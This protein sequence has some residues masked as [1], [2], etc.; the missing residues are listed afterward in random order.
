MRIIYIRQQDYW[1]FPVSVVG[2]LLIEVFLYAG[3]FWMRAISGILGF[4]IVYFVY[5]VIRKN[6]DRR[7]ATHYALSVLTAASLTALGLY[8]LTN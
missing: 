3:V 4:S 1:V 8:L 7:K 2:A 6:Y 5:F